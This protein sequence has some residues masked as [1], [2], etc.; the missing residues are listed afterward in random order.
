MKSSLKMGD[1]IKT[2]IEKKA[3]YGDQIILIPSGA[4]CL[5]CEVFENDAIMIETPDTLP[6][7]L[8]LFEKGEYIKIEEEIVKNAK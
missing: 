7:G 8:V 4:I 3:K 2:L 5:V 1:Y 6:F